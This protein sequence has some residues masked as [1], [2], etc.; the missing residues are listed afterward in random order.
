[1]RPRTLLLSA[2]LATLPGC[3]SSTGPAR[4]DAV[5]WLARTPAT[6]TPAADSAAVYAITTQNAVVSLDRGTG[7]L[8]WTARAA[9][10]EL[11]LGGDIAI[12]GDVVVV[13]TDEGLE[14]FAR[15]DGQPAWTVPLTVEPSRDENL[16][17][18][19]G[20]AVYLTTGPAVV[21]VS[22]TTG[23]ARWT[24]DLSGGSSLEANEPALRD[25]LL[26]VG[27]RTPP[28]VEPSGGRLLALD[29]TTGAERWSYTFQPAQPGQGAGCCWGGPVFSGSRVL[30]SADDG[31]IYSFSRT[32]GAVEWTAPALSVADTSIA[33]SDRR[34]L[35]V[36]GS[37]VVAGSKSGYLTGYDAATGAERWRVNPGLGAA[38]TR[39]GSDST[40]VYVAFSLPLFG[41]SVWQPGPLAAFDAATGG[42]RWRTS[43]E[44]GFN[45]PV[46]GDSLVYAVADLLG[47]YALRK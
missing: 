47:L 28:Y 37:V 9:D 40:R 10:A 32:T 26:F 36:S 16:L 23:A 27:Q 21:S 42:G 17:A 39:L 44:P 46:V 3:D 24:V 1:M 14:A 4:S 19:D 35:A 38:I 13:S 43:F 11:F 8:R 45:A 41:L 22:A 15:A 30:V 12:A 20:E 25:G 29:A 33:Q 18:G 34:P 5:V 2:L 7:A 6:L 31:R